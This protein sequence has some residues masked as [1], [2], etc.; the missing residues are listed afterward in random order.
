MGIP[1]GLSVGMGWKLE[2]GAKNPVPTAA[3]NRTKML[4]G[5]KFRAEWWGGNDGNW[6]APARHSSQPAYRL[7]NICLAERQDG[8]A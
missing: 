8:G 5:G 4:T 6:P 2:Y 1:T 7:I 3:L